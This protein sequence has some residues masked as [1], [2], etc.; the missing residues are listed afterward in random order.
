MKDMILKIK[1]AAIRADLASAVDAQ[2][3]DDA[4]RIRLRITLKPR[5]PAKP[6][7]K[8][9]HPLD[10]V[11]DLLAKLQIEAADVTYFPDACVSVCLAAPP[12]PT[13]KPAPQEK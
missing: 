11:C 12:A 7:E 3:T 13:D 8:I 5:A 10:A 6:G 4:N 1:Q 9:I 2:P